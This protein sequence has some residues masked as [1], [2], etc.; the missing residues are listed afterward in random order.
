MPALKLR[1]R[2]LLWICITSVCLTGVLHHLTFTQ[3]RRSYLNLERQEMVRNVQR[4]EQGLRQIADDLQVKAVDW[5]EWDDSYKF[6]ADHNREYI[7]SNLA[8]SALVS[9]KM[10]I[11]IYLDTQ[12]RRFEV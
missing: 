4:T 5:A 3:L 2:L 7:K 6:M 1:T 12:G 8:E 9:M 10:D 11:L